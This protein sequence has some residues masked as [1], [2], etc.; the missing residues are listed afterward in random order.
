M[1]YSIIG[2]KIREL[3][4]AIGIT[5][6][7]LADGICTQALVSRME[8][9]DIYPSATVLYRISQK[10]G[11]DVNYFFEIGSTER[12]DYIK[13]VERLLNNYRFKLQYDELIELVRKEEKNP[14][15]INHKENKQLLEWNKAIYIAEVENDKD[16]AI[17]VLLDAY[18]L[19]ADQKRAMSEREM[20]LQLSLGN[21][22]SLQ[23]KY[24]EA[25]A[26]YERVQDVLGP[27]PYL[28]DKSIQTRI[29]YHTARILTRLGRYDESMEY[30]KKGL[31]WTIGE[32]RLFG[33]AD[34]FYQ[35]GF[36][37]E[38]KGELEA[39]LPYFQ[40]ARN[41]FHIQKNTKF[42]EFIDGK[43]GEVEEKLTVEWE[44]QHK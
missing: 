38:M 33:I 34:L 20:R 1:D 39:S 37:L 27:N 22:L 16:R 12:F 25:L 29:Y 21:F 43:I 10:L 5:Q 15:F 32:E 44:K 3:R 23:D 30:C 13:N 40:K 7:E 42:V 28:Q 19:T 41:Y 4:K 18:Q 9:G 24:E 36:N 17:S 11:V 35:I 2:K 26:V 14:I 31:K 8:K 6:G